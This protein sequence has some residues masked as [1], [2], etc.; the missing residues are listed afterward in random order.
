MKRLILAALF[1]GLLI[2][3]AEAA[4]R[5]AVCTTT[6]TWDN[7]S[8]AMWSTSS[9][10]ATGASAPTT[11]DDVTF[12][13]ATCVGGTTCTTTVNA[14]LSVKSLHFTTCTASTAGCI[15]DFS[16]N[17]NNITFTNGNTAFLLVGTGTRTLNMGNGSWTF[18][19]NG[20]QTAID[21]GPNAP[22]ISGLTFNSNNSTIITNFSQTDNQIV[23]VIF[24]TL[25][26]ANI[27]VN[28]NTHGATSNF[29]GTP[30]FSGNYTINGPNF[31]DYNTG[32]I[33]T[34]N[35]NFTVSGTNTQLV[36]F[37]FAQW[38]VGGT[39]TANWVWLEG[40][41]C[42]VAMT[43]NNSFQGGNTT[44]CTINAPA[45]GGT[46]ACILGGWLLWRDMPG[47][48]N[49]NYPAWLDKAA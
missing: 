34:V 1:L 6:C 19:Q 49:D 36:L 42:F 12:D 38:S 21:A 23:S 37:H 22:S 32:G 45:G 43:F 4:A 30:T 31:L 41:V 8:T 35:G 17:N 44:G 14:N 15:L 13:A 27:T 10:G 47:R 25:T 9:G 24:N 28:G 18:N 3:E 2:F 26:W 5:F 7:S 33:S 39:T 20:T 46:T 16:A 48:L 40:S 11:T 29:V